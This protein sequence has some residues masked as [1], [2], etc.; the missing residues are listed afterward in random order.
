MQPSLSIAA[1]ERDTGLS[2]D[3]L[4]MWERRYGFPRPERDA[5]GERLYPLD[6]VERLRL[7]KRVM[8]LGYR[9]G[10]LMNMPTEQLAALEPRRHR[11][12]GSGN[13]TAAA[14]LGK[15]LEPLR[16]HDG[17]S[18][19]AGL[20]QRLARQ[21]LDTFVRTTLAPLVH[22]VGEAWEEG[23]LEVFEEHLFTELVKRLLR[24]SIAD[25]PW[26]AGPPRVLLTTVP[27]EEHTLGLL[28]I[29]ALLALDGAECVPLGP[30]TPILE[31]AAAARAHRADVVALSFSVAFPAR[32]IPT[33]VQELQQVLP[34]GLT[35][36][37]GGAGSSRV[38][39]ASG[40]RSTR[41]LDGA[42][43]ALAEWRAARDGRQD[44]GMAA[45]EN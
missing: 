26:S 9:P 30:Q 11:S 16:R 32:Q 10:K 21:G 7:I 25:L 2:K 22:L 35:L 31:I 28:M 15:L 36:W 8:D 29:E 17:V 1:V 13:E 44:E 38:P 3:L 18:F 12:V 42:V 6:Q 37:I 5:D 23:R 45:G 41:S 4:R 20:R 33:L 40:I 34:P 43:A 39:D 19:L 24:Q 27:G 14:N